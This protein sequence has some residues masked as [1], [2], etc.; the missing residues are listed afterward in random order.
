MTA[1]SSA[2]P[3]GATA[4]AAGS[5]P[6]KTFRAPCEATLLRIYL[7][8]DDVF[9]SRPLYDQLVLKARSLGIAGATVT[10]GLLAYG[11]ATIEL[12]SRLRLSEDLP[13]VLE[14]IDDEQNIRAFLA[15][16]DDMLESSV[17]TLQ[18]VTVLRYGRKTPR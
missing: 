5:P 11:P 7:G 3:S 12:E 9:E 14:I 18:R 15:V 8:D 13:V 6:A 1:K 4:A 2:R 16:A 10:R 17:V